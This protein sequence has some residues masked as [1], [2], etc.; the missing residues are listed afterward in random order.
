MGA[1]LVATWEG[2][3]LEILSQMLSA[4]EIRM[5]VVRADGTEHTVYLDV[6]GKITQQTEP[7]Q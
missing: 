5:D 7:G 2:T 3:M 1:Q 4:D 6:A